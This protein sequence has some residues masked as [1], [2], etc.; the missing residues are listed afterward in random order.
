[1]PFVAGAQFSAA[2]ITA[3]VIVDFATAAFEMPIPEE[4]RALRRWYETVAARPSAR[5]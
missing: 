5:A 3:V 4:R 1:V 2:D